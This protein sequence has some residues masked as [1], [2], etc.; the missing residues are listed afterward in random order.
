MATILYHPFPPLY[1]SHSRVLIL[2]S[3][4]SVV[5]REQSFYYANKSNRFWPVLSAVYEEEIT[6]RKVVD[7]SSRFGYF[8]V[9]GDDAKLIRDIVSR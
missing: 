3:F 7:S 8:I 5:S 4:P 2:G 1:D 6:D 9:A